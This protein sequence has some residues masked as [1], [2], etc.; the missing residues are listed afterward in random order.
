MRQIVFVLL[1]AGCGSSAT[2][3]MDAGVDAATSSDAAVAAGDLGAGAECTFNR[4]CIAEARCACDESTGCF[5]ELGARGTGKNGVDACTTGN[6][7]ASSLC[8][9]GPGGAYVCSDECNDVNDCGGKLPLC[10]NVA[11][12]GKICARSAQ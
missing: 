6:D 9:E 8:V 1:L 11:L 5:C 10:V 4:D 3:G 12:L 2:Q 7:C